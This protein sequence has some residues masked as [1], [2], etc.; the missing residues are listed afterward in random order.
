MYVRRSNN[1]HSRRGYTGAPAETPEGEGGLEQAR[2]GAH[3]EGVPV[4]LQTPLA[5][6][7]STQQ[8]ALQC[9]LTLLFTRH[10]IDTFQSA[11][12]PML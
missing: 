7:V 9:K 3:G 10:S 4:V 5:L 12:V 6:T 11:S 1:I 8:A 2:A